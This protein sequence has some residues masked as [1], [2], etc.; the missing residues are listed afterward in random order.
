MTELLRVLK[1]GGSL[2]I[3]EHDDN[4]AITHDLILIEHALYNR[5]YNLFKQGHESPIETPVSL[6]SEDGWDTYL[7]SLGLTKFGT[8]YRDGKNSKNSN[9]RGSNNNNNGNS[10]SH[11]NSEDKDNLS[12][13]TRSFYTRW[14]KPKPQVKTGQSIEKGG[15]VVINDTQEAD[16]LSSYFDA[17]NT[18]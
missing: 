13:P 16:V 7:T 4:S 6:K 9:S 2:L 10:I 8:T 18:W 11:N 14:I 15:K 12:D 3:K 1:P 17:L 5:R